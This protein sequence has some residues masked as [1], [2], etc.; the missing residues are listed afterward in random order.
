MD[1][2]IDIAHQSGATVIPHEKVDSCEWV[3]TEYA[4]KTIYEW[5]LI[6]DPDE[7]LTQGLIT[8]IAQL[9]TVGIGEEIGSITAPWIFYFKGEKLNGTNWGGINRRV[10]LIH[11][12]RFK[13]LPLIHVSRT[14]LPGFE[15][16]DIQF[17]GQNNIIHYWM[18]GYF[19]LIEKHLRYLKHEGLAR[20]TIGKRTSIKRIIREPYL[21]FKYSYYNRRGFRDG[22]K[23]LFLSVFWA[24]YETMA[25]VK[26]LK[27]QKKQ[28]KN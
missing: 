13:F 24:W 3:H 21:S 1:D 2:S 22:F 6:T 17:N 11:N 16:Y 14:L 19:K 5:V 20:F 7:I 25:Q 9:F 8:E 27:Q 12:K 26:T 23:G 28:A 15:Q 18:S 10:L 4:D